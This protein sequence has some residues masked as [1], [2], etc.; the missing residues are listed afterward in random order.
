MM[1]ELLA[2]PLAYATF[3]E[4]LAGT[5][6]TAFIDNDAVMS[7]LLHGSAGCDDVNLAIGQIWLDLARMRIA[8]GAARVESRANIADGPTR[9][10]FTLLQEL[11]AIFFE[12]ALPNWLDEL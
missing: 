10:Q 5:S 9:D 3:A 4:Q 8:F 2:V 1:Q 7:A 11:K 6:V 12:P